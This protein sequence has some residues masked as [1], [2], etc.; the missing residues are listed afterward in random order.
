MKDL[1]E[2]F[3]KIFDKLYYL[4]PGYVLLGSLV[5]WIG[6]D[7]RATLQAYENLPV[8]TG[9][10]I[11]YVLAWLLS[12]LCE[13]IQIQFVEEAVRG[14]GDRSKAIS[15]LLGN[16]H[17]VVRLQDL[18]RE[19]DEIL[20]PRLGLRPVP[21]DDE[22]LGPREALKICRAFQKR[23]GAAQLARPRETVERDMEVHEILNQAG[24]LQTDFRVNMSMAIALVLVVIQC[25]L[26]V[27][28]HVT[29]LSFPGWSLRSWERFFG[30]ANTRYELGVWN[31]TS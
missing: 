22:I 18:S 9:L 5:L 4:C 25:L 6:G 24:T 20:R 31:A 8:L 19:V 27:V 30:S 29:A 28:L 17:L 1:A 13:Q 26:R 15:R 16:P 21:H 14:G 2:L 10:L 11:G 23:V 12:V 7:V 3:D